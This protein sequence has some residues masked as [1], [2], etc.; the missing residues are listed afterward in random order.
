[1]RSEIVQC[2]L[3]ADMRNGHDGLAQLAKKHELNVLKLEPGQ[4]IVFVNSARDRVKVYAASNVIAYLKL[5]RGKI[6]MNTIQEIPKAFRGTGRIDYDAALKEALTKS[7][8][9][10]GKNSLEVFRAMRAAGVAA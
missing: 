6:D 2:F 1:M 10:K 9:R 4:Y 8:A 7:M 5:A 3:N